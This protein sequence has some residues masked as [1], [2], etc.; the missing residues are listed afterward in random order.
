MSSLVYLLSDPC[1]LCYTLY[2]TLPAKCNPYALS[3]ILQ[4]DRS[5]SLVIF[6]SHQWLSGPSEGERVPDNSNND[7]FNLC[8]QGIEEFLA[9]HSSS[10]GDTPSNVPEGK[11][12]P[13]PTASPVGS[14]FK[15]PLPNF[16]S[17]DSAISVRSA[18]T[19]DE[20]KPSPV[21]ECY[22]WIDYS[23][24]MQLASIKESI[25]HLDVIMSHCDVVFTPLLGQ[26]AVAAKR[27]KSV[28]YGA[29]N[30][31][32]TSA[33]TTTTDANSSDSDGNNDIGINIGENTANTGG[34]KHLFSECLSHYG[35]CNPKEG[36][37][38]RAWCRLELFLGRFI[39]PSHSDMSPST[40]KALKYRNKLKFFKPESPL[41]KSLLG[42]ERL[43]VICHQQT[44]NTNEGSASRNHKK[45]VCCPILEVKDDEEL[46]DEEVVVAFSGGTS[47]KTV[48]VI[49]NYLPKPTPMHLSYYN[50][51]KGLVA[52]KEDLAV[53]SELTCRLQRAVGISVQPL[54]PNN[55]LSLAGISNS[56]RMSTDDGDETSDAKEDSFVES[57]A[58]LLSNG[59]RYVGSTLNGFLHGESC[60][61][62]SSNGNKYIGGFA[63][64]VKSGQGRFEL[65][66]PL[67]AEAARE[68]LT[69]A[70]TPV[71]GTYEGSDDPRIV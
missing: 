30:I 60:V 71:V 63:N 69:E 51:M 12:S 66:S 27:K 70:L 56:F 8:V 68:M 15:P 28:V 22:L 43:H 6:I 52:K 33:T 4:I 57:T 2:Y 25:A 47:L 64:N 65:V 3:R 7:Q 59:D 50:P 42:N 18:G 14:P 9:E 10:L 31:S 39:P 55:T 61:L 29:G 32:N 23:S 54:S 53:I 46:S 44:G 49:L 58:L 19:L 16:R 62:T 1:S 41:Y 26:Q 34:G 11:K 37:L 17:N 48:E 20:V 36:Y 21:L 45:E 40:E 35:W 5:S 24:T 13:S 38:T 67:T